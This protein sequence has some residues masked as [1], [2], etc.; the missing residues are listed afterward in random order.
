MEPYA[1]AQSSPRRLRIGLVGTAYPP[2]MGGMEVYLQELA[3][4]LAA[5]EHAVQVATRFTGQRPPTMEA[6]HQ[7]VEPPLSET[8]GKVRVNRL[9]PTWSGRIALKPV[10]RL[11]FRS[12]TRPLA[13][14]LVWHAFGQPLLDALGSCDVI[15]YSGHG[16]RDAGLCRSE[17][18][19]SY[20]YPFRGDTSYARRAWGD[21]PI[22][23][24]LYR[25]ADRVIA[26][27]HD[28]RERLETLGVEAERLSVVG[29]GVNVRG[30]GDENAFRAQH[31]IDGPIV[32]TW[33]VRR[34]TRALVFYNAPRGWYGPSNRRPVRVCRTRRP[35]RASTARPRPSRSR[36]RS[37]ERPPS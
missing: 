18:C 19:P 13:E 11:H 8:R 7:S 37:G 34:R 23:L 24:A 1:T 20:E 12:S 33:V 35:G 29:H 3:G 26:L 4:A 31:A 14:R 22:D 32:F 9:S 5:E 6:L 27:T 17:A 30:D 36:S 16:T 28:E 25:Q 15:H 2:V 21:G 10:Y